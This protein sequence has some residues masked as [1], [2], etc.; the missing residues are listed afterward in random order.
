M[1]IGYAG[2]LAGGVAGCDIGICKMPFG[3]VCFCLL[4]VSWPVVAIALAGVA[5]V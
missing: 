3:L 1:E 5:S 4:L 2:V